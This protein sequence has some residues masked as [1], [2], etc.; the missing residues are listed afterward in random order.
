MNWIRPY[1][2]RAFCTAAALAILL[3]PVARPASGQPA[4]QRV[5]VTNQGNF[6]DGN[7][8]ITIHD[9]ADGT[10]INDIG[11]E[12]PSIFQSSAIV[13]DRV[14]V[15]SNTAEQIDIL[16]LTTGERIGQIPDVRSPRYMLV[17]GQKAYVTNLYKE[18]F[19]GG[20][21]TVIDLSVDRVVATIDVADNPEGLARLGDMLYVASPAFGFGS[22]VT[23][24]NTNTDEVVSEIVME[25]DGPR[26]LA[27]TRN[28]NLLVFCTGQT[29]WNANFSQILSTT[30][31][32]V[33]EL[34]P[35][36][37]AQTAWFSKPTSD[38]T[39]GPGQDDFYSPETGEAYSFSDDM[40]FRAT[41][42]D[43]RVDTLFLGSGDRIGALAYDPAS[44]LLYVGH[45]P[46]ANPF[47]AAGYV[48]AYDREGTEV[49]RFDAGIAPMHIT[50][51]FAEA[52]AMEDV[53]EIPDVARI[54]SVY[55][56]P[57]SDLFSV[58]LDVNRVTQVEIELWSATGQRVRALYAGTLNAGFH[59]VHSDGSGLASGAY[60]VALRME[61]RP[62][63]FRPIVLTR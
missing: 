18:N 6:A 21:V 1:V 39:F 26:W 20:T 10:T 8:S 57:S 59:T 9:P 7:G 3:T 48:S 49:F 13:G 47:T 17:H 2:E 30:D 46:A 32:I 15:M 25:C 24:I 56:N 27:A 14:Y 4:V 16:S 63:E 31:G 29:V 23:A 50:F 58:E 40:V 12:I 61:D 11:L 53:Q 28:D 55:P 37:G 42:A 43:A 62:I 44:A 45:A 35:T 19:A 22:T 60:F 51:A 41:D 5:V 38:Q 33:I 54:A 36:T 52:T 34:D